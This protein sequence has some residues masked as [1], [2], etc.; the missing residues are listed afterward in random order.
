MKD[1]E[2]FNNWLL[3]NLPLGK[4][5]FDDADA[6]DSQDHYGVPFKTVDDMI[7]NYLW[8]ITMG[9]YKVEKAEI[10]KSINRNTFIAFLAQE[11]KLNVGGRTTTDGIN[12]LALDFDHDKN[13]LENLQ[14]DAKAK[15]VALYQEILAPSVV[16]TDPDCDFPINATPSLQSK[17]QETKSTNTTKENGTTSRLGVFADKSDPSQSKTANKTASTFEGDTPC[18]IM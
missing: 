2:M 16:H 8:D 6:A 11:K 17:P 10:G 7:K 15:F 4:I 12:L 18:V 1:I 5:V 14:K 9:V 3:A 13:N